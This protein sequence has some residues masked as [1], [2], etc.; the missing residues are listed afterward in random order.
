MEKHK[1]IPNLLHTESLLLPKNTTSRIQLLDAGV[2]A[3]IK[4]QFRVTQLKC[5]IH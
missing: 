3:W 4:K 1:K 5:V 2:I